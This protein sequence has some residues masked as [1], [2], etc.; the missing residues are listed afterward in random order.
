MSM[1]TWEFCNALTIISCFP[2]IIE[3][4]EGLHVTVIAAS[5]T[6]EIWRLCPLLVNMLN[7]ISLLWEVMLWIPSGKSRFNLT[8]VSEP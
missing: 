2:G 6:L 5:A 7:V 4:Q 8:W 3:L 1:L